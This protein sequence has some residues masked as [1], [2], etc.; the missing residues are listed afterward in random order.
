MPNMDDLLNI[1]NHRSGYKK[2]WIYLDNGLP[3]MIVARYDDGQEKTYRQFCLKNDDWIEG[4]PPSP[5]PLPTLWAPNIKECFR[6]RLS[7]H[8]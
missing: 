1:Q 7:H 3:V 4:M 8:Y 6:S 5:I 2:H